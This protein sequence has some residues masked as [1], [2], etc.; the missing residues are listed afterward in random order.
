MLVIN[1][2]RTLAILFGVGLFKIYQK[3]FLEVDEGIV[4]FLLA[5]FGLTLAAIVEDYVFKLVNSKNP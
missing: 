5:F 3:D 2:I 1:L 4:I